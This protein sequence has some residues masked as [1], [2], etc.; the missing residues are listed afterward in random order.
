MI[1][2]RG[3]GLDRRKKIR[4]PYSFLGVLILALLLC[5]ISG[6]AKP[7]R[8]LSRGLTNL[9][10]APLEVILQ[11]VKSVTIDGETSTALGSGVARGF[12]LWGLRWA[13]AFYD[14]ATFYKELPPEKQLNV[15][16]ETILDGFEAVV[17]DEWKYPEYGLVKPGATYENDQK[18]PFLSYPVQG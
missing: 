17:H 18:Q 2:M 14:L 8:K 9:A 16:P 15:E 1:P 10:T 4:H 7:Y 11:P 3:T 5:P 6:E 12:Y 13:S